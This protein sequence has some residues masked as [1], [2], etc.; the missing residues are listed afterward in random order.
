MLFLV[1][2]TTGLANSAAATV[3]DR[4]SIEVLTNTNEHL[5]KQLLTVAK[6]L[7]TVLEKISP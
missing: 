7:T 3:T 6:N 2:I 4:A 5:S 1:G